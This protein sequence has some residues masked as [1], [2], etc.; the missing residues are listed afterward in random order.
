MLKL[1]PHLFWIANWKRGRIIWLILKIKLSTTILAHYHP[2]MPPRNRKK[3]LEDLHSP[4]LSQ[5]KIFHPSGNLMFNNLG[6]S[7]SLKLRTSMGKVL[8]ISLKL[9]FSPNT[10]GL[11]GRSC[12]KL[13]ID[14]I[15]DWCIFK[16]I[17]QIKLFPWFTLSYRKQG[18]KSS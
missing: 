11:L 6:V 12:W 13:S 14:M 15:F 8:R 10:F 3:N 2:V 7:Q 1:V 9:N 18:L 17:T 16:N 5:L 4:V